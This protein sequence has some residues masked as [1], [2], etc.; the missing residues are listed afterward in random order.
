MKLI[1]NLS[2]ILIKQPIQITSLHSEINQCCNLQ[3]V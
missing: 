2:Y 3:N 1:I